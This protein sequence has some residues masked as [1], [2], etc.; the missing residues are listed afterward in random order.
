MTTIEGVDYSF[1]R[2]TPSA[3]RAAGKRFAVRY[4]GPG[5][6]SK[7]LTAAEVRA[8]AAAGIDVVA[9]AEG[10]AG[11]FKTAAVGKSWA[12]SAWNAARALGMPVNRPIYFSVDWDA[13]SGDWAGIDAAL[14]AA[15]GVIGG[16]L[17]GVYGSYDVIAHCVSAKTAKWFWQTYAWSGGRQHPRANLYQYKNGVTIGGGDLDLTRALTVD[18]GQWDFF[19]TEEDMPLT[20]ADADLL[21][22]RMADRINNKD[23]AYCSANRATPWQF[24]GNPLPAAKS[25][26]SVL[27]DI[28]QATQAQA[29]QNAA[30][31][32]AIQSVSGGQVD[33][34]AL[35]DQVSADLVEPLKAALLASLPVDLSDEIR[36]DIE[37]AAESVASRF[38]LVVDPPTA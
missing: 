16:D 1:A 35:A 6:A 37:E 24:S 38:R 28:W 12:T 21:I 9:N 31:L 22:N 15:A 29:A 7:H 34:A 20:T 27:A 33:V 30:L 14:R 10:A 36:A 23:D 2:P 4:V 5:S 32:S 13:D 19:T 3:L 17:V 18:Y 11:A 26:A 25:S 8:L